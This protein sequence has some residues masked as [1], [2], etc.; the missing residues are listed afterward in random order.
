MRLFHEAE[1]LVCGKPISEKMRLIAESRG[2]PARFCSPAHRNAWNVKQ[3]RLKAKAGQ[4]SIRAIRKG[5]FKDHFGFDVD[6]YVLDDEAKTA[7]I[8]QRGMGAVLG[9]GEAGN[10]LPKL[11]RSQ[12]VTKA[13]GSEILER[14]A[15]GPRLRCNP[16]D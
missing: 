11:L 2:T 6:C 10:A 15:C 3:S 13:V 5:N 1:C 4:A 12:T 14:S 8:S 9:L 7:V 16:P